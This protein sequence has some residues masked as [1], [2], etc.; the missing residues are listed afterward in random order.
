MNFDD[1]LDTQASVRRANLRRALQLV[2]RSPGTQTRAGIARSTGLTAATASSLVAELIESRLILDGEQAASTGGKR[3]TTLSIDARHHVIVVMVI[4]PAY[5]RLAVLAL[6]G[7]EVSSDR[8]WF[9]AGAREQVL[10]EALAALRG[11]YGDR[12]LIA[13]AQVPGA[14]DGRT[15]LESVQLGWS[16]V[17]LAER[18]ESTIG[19]PALLVNDVDAEAIAEVSV[20][21]DVTGYRLFLHLGTGIGAAVTLDAELAPGPRDRAG[22]IG[23]VQVEF[24]AGAVRCRC[25]R[26]GC[27]ESAASLTAMLG[28][29]FSDSLDAHAVAAL[30]S[31]TPVESLARGAS[32]LARVITL[33]SALLDPTEVV[34]G[35]PATAL[36]ERFLDLV[37]AETDY[38][39]TGTA[40]VPIRYADSRATAFTGASQLALTAALGVRWNADRPLPTTP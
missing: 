7:S 14:T 20:R 26:L 34:I 16:G 25:G 27:L 18:I 3:A 1:A 15:V 37:R 33:T 40:Y 6:D 19:A 29:E 22:E 9:D 21:G 24:G 17:P 23:H 11:H 31:A 36:G 4:Q 2:F 10:D 5:A 28:S 32:A 35:G 13:A 39:A 8:L 38:V 30:A 12:I